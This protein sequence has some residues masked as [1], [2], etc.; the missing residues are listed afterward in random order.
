MVCSQ[1]RAIVIV[2]CAAVIIVIIALI[3]AFARPP[4]GTDSYCLEPTELPVKE[5]DQG[6]GLA[7]NGEVFPWTDIRLP[8]HVEPVEYDLFLHPN[9]THFDFRGEVAMTVR[10]IEETDFIV[11]HM[12]LLNYTTVKITEKESGKFLQNVKVLEYKHFEQVYV[13]TKDRLEEGKKYVVTI[14]YEGE[15]ATSLVGFYRSS[16]TTKAGEKRLEICILFLPHCHWWAI[17][18]LLSCPKL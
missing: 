17:L 18:I 9:L 15:L 7:T 14:T 2:C 1:S 4:A 16:Y 13:Q 3:A 8:T 5:D 11:F 10:V 6:D 12:K